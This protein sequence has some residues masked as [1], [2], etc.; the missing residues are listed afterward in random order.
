MSGTTYFPAAED[1]TRVHFYEGDREF[2]VTSSGLHFEAGSVA[3]EALVSSGVLKTGN[4]RKNTSDAVV[5][6]ATFPVITPEHHLAVAETNIADPSRRSRR[7]SSSTRTTLLRS[8][9]TRPRER[10]R[11]EV[12]ADGWNERQR[13]NLR[14]G[15]AVRERHRRRGEHPQDEVHRW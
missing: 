14:V 9:Q 1:T 10:P 3:A 12:R 11:R 6:A 8:S 4:R 2:E 13:R 5:E 7:R 15:E